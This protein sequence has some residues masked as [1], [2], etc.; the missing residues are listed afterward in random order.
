M[1]AS[2]IEL[3]P[4]TLELAE[5]LAPNLRPGDVAEAYALGLHP[6]VALLDSVRKSEVA[7][8]C[9]FGGELSCIFG[10]MTIRETALGGRLGL[11]WMLSGH[12]VNRHPKSFLRTSRRVVD[13][14][15][16]QWDELSNFI[17]SRYDAA[18]RW[19]KWLGFE[20]QPPI[21]L[22]GMTVPFCRFTV[23]R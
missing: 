15:L 21:L 14:L 1:A 22:P 23:R 9:I 4:A 20:I 16:T 7:T 10:A 5:E 3:V 2:D 11:V 13:E 17:D 12:G 8:A 6:R 18:L 19:A